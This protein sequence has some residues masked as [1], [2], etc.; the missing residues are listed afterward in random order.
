VDL[1]PSYAEAHN[2]LSWVHQLLGHPNE[3]LESAKRAVEL[4]PLSPEAVSNL[5]ISYLE[6]GAFEQALAEAQ[7]DRELGSSWGSGR[8]Y[9]GLAL[10]ELERFEEA[11]SV[12]QDLSTPWADVGPRATLALVHVAAGDHEKARAMLAQFEDTGHAFAAGLIHAALGDKEAA[13]DAFRRVERW[14]DYWPTLAVRHYYRDVW[15]RLRADP[16]YEQLLRAVDHSW[17]L[18]ERMPA[19]DNGPLQPSRSSDLDPYAIAVLPFSTLSENENASPFAAGLHNDLLTTLSR[20]GALTVISHSSVLQYRDAEIPISEIAHDLKAG[21]IVE[22]RVQ[23]APSRMR[24]NVQLTDA[25]DESLRWAETYDRELTAEN[26]FDI[27]SE[28]AEKIAGSLQAKLT[29]EERKRVGQR[30]TNDLEAY[31]LYAQGRRHLDERTEAGIRQAF[32]DFQCAIEQDAD[33]ALAWAGLADT[34]SLFEFYG[35]TQLDDTRDPIQAARRAVE[36]DPELGEAHAS[37]GIRHAIRQEGPAALQE[38]KRAVELTPSYAEAHVWLGWVWLCLGHPEKGLSFSE[39]AVELNPL[40]PAF[41]VYLA[42]NYLACGRTED[43]FRQAQRAREIQPEYGLTHFMEG[44]VLYHQ[45]RWVA[46]ASALQRALP[47]VPP[48][49]TPTHAEVQAALAVTHA[50]TGDAPQALKL[51]DRIDEV[52]APFSAGLVHAALGDSDAA[53]DAFERIRNWGSFETEHVRYF[54]PDVLGALRDESRYKDLIRRLNQAWGL[55]P[56]G[57]LPKN[58]RYS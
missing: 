26:L 30:P 12:L 9:E 14:G 4:N 24:L 43:A 49:G 48:Q 40:A 6:N 51:L 46:A 21:T 1:Q 39:R 42:E 20:M 28:L 3:A 29:S 22:G 15:N 56:D 38:L 2:W 11:K 52:G 55:A 17:G 18:I 47:L 37:L 5:S 54:F 53:F 8:F 10:Y 7:R 58:A 44:L 34:F 41:H 45:G 32:D 25:R 33:Y 50:V 57:G 23:Q 31:R 16:R 35:F 13:F 27:Q 19:R 36:L